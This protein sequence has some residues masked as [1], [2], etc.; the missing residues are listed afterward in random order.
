VLLVHDSVKGKEN[1][2]GLKSSVSLLP[3]AL[4]SPYESPLGNM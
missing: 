2:E 3:K 1:F 4:T